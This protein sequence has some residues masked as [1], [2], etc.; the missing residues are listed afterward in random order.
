MNACRSLRFIFLCFVGSFGAAHAQAIHEY[1][2]RASK[3]MKK[4]QWVEAHSLLS[5]ATEKFDKLAM[6]TSGPR[7]GWF[8]YQKG[9]CELKLK[10]YDEAANSFRICYEKYPNR[11]SKE[12]RKS[13]VNFYHKKALLMWGD[14]AKGS[15]QWKRSLELYQQFLNE[16]DKNRDAY[17]IGVLH[18]N[19]ATNYYELGKFDQGHRFLEKALKNKVEWET[20][21]AAIMPVFETLVKKSIELKKEGELLEFLAKN[22]SHIKLAPFEGHRYS[23]RL[24]NFAIKAHD[25]EMF[26]TS[27]ELYSLIPSTISVIDDLRA[28]LSLLGSYDG[29]IRDGSMV[30]KRENLHSD[31]VSL[32]QSDSNGQVSEIYAYLNTAALHEQAGNV[33]GA[34]AVYEQLE[35]YFPNAAIAQVGGNGEQFVKKIRE[36][37]LFH[38][39]RTSAIVGD[40]FVTEKYG[41]LFLRDFPESRFVH[42]VRQ[43]MLL[44]LFDQGEFRKCVE[45]AE[46]M[47][48]KLSQPS[49]EHE[50]CLYVL[51]GSHHYLAHFSVAQP[52]LDQYLKTYGKES[53]HQMRLMAVSYFQAANRYRL[54]E[55]RAAA[56]L[57]DRF[58]RQYPE[59]RS[60]HYYSYALFDRATCH[61][62]QDELEP[63]L[64]LVNRVEREFP[65]VSVMESNLALKGNILESLKRNSEAEEY[66]IKALRL[67]ERRKADPVAAECL[68][69][70]TS[71]LGKEIAAGRKNPRIKESVGYYHQFWERYPDSILKGKMAVAGL[72]GM[73]EMGK[74]EE[75]L[76]RLQTVIADISDDPKGD[77]L[78]ELIGSYTEAYLVE[79]SAEQLKDHYYNFRGIDS[80]NITTRALLRV[81]MVSVFEKELKKAERVKDEK[82]VMRAKA[83]IKVIFEQL[84]GDE[85]KLQK[86][87]PYVL[88]KIGKYINQT[89][90]P[91]EAVR[92]FQEA[93]ERKQSLDDR[94][95]ALSGLAESY[96]LDGTGAQKREAIQLLKKV[97]VESRSR[98]QKSEALYRTA[99]IH[100][101]LKDYQ[102]AVEGAREYINNRRFRM[103]NVECRFLLAKSHDRSGKIE[104]AIV[105]YQNFLLPSL[106]GSIQ[107]SAPS[108]HRWMELLWERNG[109]NRSGISDRQIAYDSGKKYLKDTSKAMQNP[110]VSEEEHKVYRRVIQLVKEYEAHSDTVEEV[111]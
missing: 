83:D 104:D 15:E 63:A 21:N 94:L 9:L 19:L 96:A 98:S 110:R 10:R 75:G 101:E 81:A 17:H 65:G 85:F 48:P 51:G 92:Y 29:V 71:L 102:K 39:V 2:D 108:V 53:V 57:L 58:L 109:K 55:Y 38:L 46:V 1:A 33:R 61:Y 69:F 37:N 73:V 60:N 106:A 30:L 22:R 44:S 3:A 105:S 54:Y 80:R 50:L 52:L 25:S 12:G 47:M 68:Y 103:R 86:M 107:Y 91:I 95:S 5:S 93:L 56:R 28:R 79:H 11:V 111:K 45:L 88:I 31:L 76:Q 77:E 100:F 23:R 89:R 18:V 72:P 8:W 36:E 41:S 32:M 16:R 84:Q 59:P 67:A 34:Y 64:E 13:S 43:M 97:R 66:Y 82:G 27:F 62:S 7:F 99:K 78:E 90:S 40:V 14:A 42:E 87:S 24:I 74:R 49:H 35:L 70:L 4:N 26:Q 6:V 20:P